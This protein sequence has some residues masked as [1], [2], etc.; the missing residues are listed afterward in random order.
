MTAGLLGIFL[1]AWGAH[2]FYMGN[3]SATTML[4]VSLLGCPMIGGM[5]MGTIGVVE[6]IMYLTKSDE[7]FY[8]TYIRNKKEWF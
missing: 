1:G 5:V 2:K 4:L 7:E 8:D 6:G 3:S